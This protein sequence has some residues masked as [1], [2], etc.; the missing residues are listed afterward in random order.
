MSGKKGHK[1][2]PQSIEEVVTKYKTGVPI[3]ELSRE[4]EIS[5]Y[6]IQS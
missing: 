4:Y 3:R 5:R 1:H 6:A 2:Y